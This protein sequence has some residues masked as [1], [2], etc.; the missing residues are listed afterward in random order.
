MLL[1]DESVTRRAGAHPTTITRN[2]PAVF[3]AL[4]NLRALSA[5]AA[6]ELN[7]LGHDGDALGV[8]GAKVGV[9]EEANEVGL[10]GLLEGKDGRSLEAEVGLEVLGDLADE[11]LE[12]KLAD[13]EVGRLLV[14]T[15]LTEGD[16]S[17]AITV[18]LLDTSGGGGR[19]AGGLGG[20][21]LA[22]GLASGGLAGGLLG[23]SHD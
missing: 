13:E 8:D 17:G 7:V 14:A 20:E 11:T 16:G 21:L 22:G 5:D 18:G 23:T 10:G 15:D 9:L 3:A 4:N 1:I 2:Q 12:G 19:L 6:G